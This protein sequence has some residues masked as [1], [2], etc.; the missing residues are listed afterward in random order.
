MAAAA[1]EEEE[2]VEQVRPGGNSEATLLVRSLQET[3]PTVP[4]VGVVRK[5][6]NEQVCRC[7]SPSPAKSD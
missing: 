5:Y 6:W 3:F 7:S 2:E 4:V 1:D